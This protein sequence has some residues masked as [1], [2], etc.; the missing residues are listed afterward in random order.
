MRLELKKLEPH[1]KVCESKD[2]CNVV[3]PS[4]HIK[5]LEFNQY[6]KS[7]KTLFI[8][9]AYLR[10]LTEKMDEWKNNPVKSSTIKLGGHIPSGFSISTILLFKETESKHDVYRVK[11][12]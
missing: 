2:F 1:K 6:Q 10:S 9:Y 3:I 8:I 4:K 11:I 7:G 5:I 12:V